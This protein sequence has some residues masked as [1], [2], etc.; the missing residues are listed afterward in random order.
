MVQLKRKGC[1]AANLAGSGV[2]RGG[3]RFRQRGWHLLRLCAEALE[4]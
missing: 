4:L 2:R 1:L 3:K